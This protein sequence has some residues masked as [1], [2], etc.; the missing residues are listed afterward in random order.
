LE[1]KVDLLIEEIAKTQRERKR[2]RI[3][4]KIDGLFYVLITMSTFVSGIII[5]QSAFLIRISIL[6]PIIGVLLSMLISFIIG[7]KGMINDS[8]ELR[9]SAWCMLAGSL[10]YYAI[11]FIATEKQNT[12]LLQYILP[13]LSENVLLELALYF[14]SALSWALVIIRNVAWWVERKLASLLQE[15]VKVPLKIWYGI[16]KTFIGTSVVALLLT[17]AIVQ[18]F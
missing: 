12:P 5:T 1:K 6:H 14:V 10:P 9:V 2:E 3:F 4:S 18:I 15:E 7:F 16:V 11:I 8:I 13:T 17:I